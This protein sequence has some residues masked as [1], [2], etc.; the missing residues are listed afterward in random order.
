MKKLCVASALVWIFRAGKRVMFKEVGW[1]SDKGMEGVR[2]LTPTAPDIY[3]D[4]WRSRVVAVPYRSR[5]CR[6][7]REVGL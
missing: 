6:R 1:D 5:V 4:F 2:E 3:G 7:Q